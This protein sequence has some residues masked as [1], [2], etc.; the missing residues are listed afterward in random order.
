MALFEI[1]MDN[2][3]AYFEY[4]VDL[5]GISYKLLYRWNGRVENWIF[6][7]FDDQDVAVQTG[8]P[9]YVSIILLAQNVRTNRP[10]GQF[11]AV[12]EAE[13]GLNPDRFGIGGDVK[14]I[15][16]ESDT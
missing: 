5:E 10:P 8:N 13:D 12:N 15:Y 4:F 14:F 11:A 1:P 2:R 9:Y 3:D 6:D 16:L 7:I